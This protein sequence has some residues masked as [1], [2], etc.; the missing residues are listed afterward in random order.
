MLPTVKLKHLVPWILLDGLVFYFMIGNIH[1]CK[2]ML[3]L[4][5]LHNVHTQVGIIIAV[6]A[7]CFLKYKMFYVI[8]YI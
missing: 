2:K 1:T 8:S 7:C 4:Q 6:P 3:R 5:I